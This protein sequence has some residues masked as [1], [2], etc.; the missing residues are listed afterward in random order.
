VLLNDTVFRHARLGLGCVSAEDRGVERGGSLGRAGDDG[1][2]ERASAAERSADGGSL[3]SVEGV[4]GL[5]GLAD[6]RLW[7]AGTRQDSPAG[8]LIGHWSSLGLKDT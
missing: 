7:Y 5:A 3:E 6:T 2:V 4:G 8:R 1:N